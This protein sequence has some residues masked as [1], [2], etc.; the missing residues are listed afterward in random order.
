MLSSD[1]GTDAI[2]LLVSQLSIILALP[3]YTD[4]IDPCFIKLL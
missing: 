4:S 1:D 2:N 3:L